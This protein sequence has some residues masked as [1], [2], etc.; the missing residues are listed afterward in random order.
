MYNGTFLH[1]DSICNCQDL[2]LIVKEIQNLRVVY[3]LDVCLSLANM[4]SG[5]SRCS[6]SDPQECARIPACLGGLMSDP[7]LLA[8]HQPLRH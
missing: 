6:G 7:V 8:I 2:G 4:R 5:E 3:R 1:T